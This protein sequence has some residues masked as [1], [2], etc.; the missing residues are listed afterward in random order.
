MIFGIKENS[1][2]LT[3]TMYFWLLLQIYPCYL[4]LVLWSRVTYE[5][6]MSDTWT[7]RWFG[8]FEGLG[9]SGSQNPSELFVHESDSIGARG[10][11]MNSVEC[12]WG[13]LIE[14]LQFVENFI[15][16]AGLLTNNTYWKYACSLT[17]WQVYHRFENCICF[18]CVGYKCFQP[19]GVN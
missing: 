18:I 10:S 9:W 5:I 4:W 19:R 15:S 11:Q 2:I 3:H 1:I 7:N 6:A 17:V 12:I 8:S 14:Y 13:E 16:V